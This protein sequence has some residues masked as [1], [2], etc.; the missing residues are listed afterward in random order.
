MAVRTFSSNSVGK[1]QQRVERHPRERGGLVGGAADRGV[2]FGLLGCVEQ[3]FGEQPV[4]EPLELGFL[5]GAKRRGRHGPHLEARFGA[6]L[7]PAI[8][9][10]VLFIRF[11]LSLVG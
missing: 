9:L 4:F 5:G 6:E 3:L 1:H 7:E 8:W 2:Q 11:F 10:F